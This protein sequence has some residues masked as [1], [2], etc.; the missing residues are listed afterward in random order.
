MFKSFNELKKYISAKE[1]AEFIKL[2]I[3]KS[4]TIEGARQ[5][6]VK[7]E[8]NPEL[9]YYQLLYMCIHS[10][11]R[12]SKSSG[13]R[14]TQKTYRQGCPFKL[15]LTASSNGAY[16]QVVEFLDKHNHVHNKETYS[17]LV[18]HQFPNR[19]NKALRRQII[20]KHGIRKLIQ[21]QQLEQ[22]QETLTNEHYLASEYF[23]E[24]TLENI[25][26]EEVEYVD[27]VV[28]EYVENEMVDNDA[29]VEVEYVEN[30]LVDNDGNGEVE[31]VENQE[32][33]KNVEVENIK[34]IK[35]ERFKNKRV[36]A[37]NIMS[38]EKVLSQSLNKLY[39]VNSKVSQLASLVAEAPIDVFCQRLNVLDDLLSFWTN[40]KEVLLLPVG[41]N[42]CDEKSKSL[43]TTT[44]SDHAYSLNSS[45]K[46]ANPLINIQLSNS[47]NELALD[48][49]SLPLQ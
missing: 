35:V 29:N 3:A 2:C 30:V 13:I 15:R 45:R 38:N 26:N 11:S 33:V 34:N 47:Y 23:I 12:V 9:K 22:T 28:V 36:K 31:Y 19:P 5:K 7:R 49:L 43:N 16:L 17:C 6:G 44:T 20:N 18:R 14:P 4:R 46:F 21:Q 41:G 27:D 32:D 10:G 25:E 39:V 24:H 37:Q 8:I 40:N 1:N 42:N 48:M